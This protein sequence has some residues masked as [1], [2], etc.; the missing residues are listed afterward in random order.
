MTPPRGLFLTTLFLS[1][2]AYLY[3]L[4]LIF[5]SYR[6]MGL[7]GGRGGCSCRYCPGESQWL[8]LFFFLLPL[9]RALELVRRDTIGHELDGWK[10]GI[11]LRESQH[12]FC[13]ERHGDETR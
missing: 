13:G 2:R 3:F 1:G 9:W 8:P 5:D 7:L 10:H 11:D 4:L 12:W 6:W